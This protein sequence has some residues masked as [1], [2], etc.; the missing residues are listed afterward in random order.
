[1]I[2][3]IIVHHQNYIQLTIHGEIP[4]DDITPF[5]FVG[6]MPPR[7]GPFGPPGGVPSM[8][9]NQPTSVSQP[10][11]SACGPPMSTAGPPSIPS[12]PFNPMGHPMA[13]GG[14]RPMGYQGNQGMPSNSMNPSSTAG[15]PIFSQSQDMTSQAQVIS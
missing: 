5:S 7:P 4:I 9:G 6:P 10:P 3:M 11:N 12:G 8:M 15:N 1:M 13:F 2:I 14:P